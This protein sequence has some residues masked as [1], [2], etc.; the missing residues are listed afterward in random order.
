M[1]LLHRIDPTTK[2]YM[3][4]SY[5]HDSIYIKPDWTLVNNPLPEN[6]NFLKFKLENNIWVEGA[7]KEEI[8][9]NRKLSIPDPISKMRLR[10]QLVKMNIPLV[11]IDNAIDGIED[12]LQRELTSIMWN[13]AVTF[14]RYDS[15]LNNIGSALGLTQEQ[16]DY[17]FI[18]GNE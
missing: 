16:I 6:S 5:Q 2:I 9:E 10:M 4:S 7:T 8:E 15:S 13:D 1:D 17:I 11:S 18:E 3:N 14:D 12:P